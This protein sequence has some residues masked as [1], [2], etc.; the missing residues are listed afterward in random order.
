MRIDPDE[1]K[2]VST[3]SFEGLAANMTSVAFGGSDLADLFVTS[4]ADGGKTIHGGKVF[5]VRGTGAQGCPGRNF[6]PY[7][8]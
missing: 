5:V 6:D 7:R 1:K 4:A 8:A 3:I 2:L